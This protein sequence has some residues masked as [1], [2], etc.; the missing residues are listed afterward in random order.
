MWNGRIRIRCISV[1]EPVLGTTNS[2][3]QG[4]D[5]DLDNDGNTLTVA[6]Q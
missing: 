1:L 5:V 2:S 3:N 4:V 6:E